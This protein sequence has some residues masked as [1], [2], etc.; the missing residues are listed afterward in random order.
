MR[1]P[2]RHRSQCLE[3]QILFCFGSECVHQQVAVVVMY[4]IVLRQV[5]SNANTV[6]NFLE[7]QA[8]YME[9]HAGSY[10]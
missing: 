7:V 8:A 6:I 2:Q 3:A 10:A 9:Q 4:V 5:F 1:L